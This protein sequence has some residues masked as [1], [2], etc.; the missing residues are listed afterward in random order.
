MDDWE[1]EYI[2]GSSPKTSAKIDFINSFRYI[3]ANSD[4]SLDSEHFWSVPMV[5][6]LERFDCRIYFHLFVYSVILYY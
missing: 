1:N 6:T 3:K 2:T 5:F 4:L